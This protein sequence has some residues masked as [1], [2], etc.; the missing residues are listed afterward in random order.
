MFLV[1]GAGI[2]AAGAYV[3]LP[4]VQD[5]TGSESVEAEVLAA[6][7]HGNS[8]PGEQGTNYYVDVRYRYTYDGAEHTSESVFPGNRD[9]QVS[10][11]RAEA[12]AGD[13]AAGDTV[14]A[15]VVPGDPPRSY[16]VETSVPWWYYLAPGFGALLVAAG[17][18]NVVQGVRGV[19]PRT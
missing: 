3:A 10:R 11:S 12:I 16:L 7:W 19:G 9:G 2:F 14:T 17:L 15:N 6:D 8:P 18:L 4:H 1:L 5:V 13:Y